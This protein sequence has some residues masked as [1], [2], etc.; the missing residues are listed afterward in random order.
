MA[1][2]CTPFNKHVWSCAVL[3]KVL[4]LTLE[5]G[6]LKLFWSDIPLKVI[7]FN[8]LNWGH[9]IN[10][11]VVPHSVGDIQTSNKADMPDFLC[12]NY[13][14]Q[15]II[16]CKWHKLWFST[17]TNI[18]LLLQITVLASPYSDPIQVTTSLAQ[19]MEQPEMLWVMGPVLAVVLI[20]IFVIAILLFK[21]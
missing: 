11:C 9:S 18:F 19:G 8:S 13:K 14:R 4:I 3:L 10:E 20:V 7:G 6:P 1:S 17:D 16:I 12:H 15:S 5:K 2:F 21:K